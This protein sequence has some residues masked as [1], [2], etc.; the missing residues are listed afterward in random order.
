LALH[1]SNI[2]VINKMDQS[3]RQLLLGTLAY[4]VVIFGVIA[5]IGVTFAGT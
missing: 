2:E 3:S 5:T 1:F 4:V